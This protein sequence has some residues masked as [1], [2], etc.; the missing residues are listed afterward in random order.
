MVLKK[1]NK[2]RGACVEGFSLATGIDDLTVWQR[3]ALIWD[4]WDQCEDSKA[5]KPTTCHTA[6]QPA[7]P[8]LLL[9]AASQRQVYR[10][11]NG[12]R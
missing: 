6:G 9:T 8:S 1:K 12:G 2:S 11:R 10:K 5:M 4:H 7:P 3:D